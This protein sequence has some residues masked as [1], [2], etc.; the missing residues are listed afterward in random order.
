MTASAGS[1]EEDF[2]DYAHGI[3]ATGDPAGLPHPITHH[4]SPTVERFLGDR[5]WRDAVLSVRSH[6]FTSTLFD[7]DRSSFQGPR[8]NLSRDLPAALAQGAFDAEFALVSGHDVTYAWYDT[9]DDGAWDLVLVRLARPEHPAV[10]AAYSRSNGA[11]AL[12]P[13]LA[14]GPLVRPNA[15]LRP[16][17]RQAMTAQARRI[18]RPGLLAP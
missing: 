15:F 3:A 8:R 14:E 13:S 6:G 16:A 11:L 18:L 10:A 17:L 4:A 5:A 7:L 2:G 1:L 9:D 12:V